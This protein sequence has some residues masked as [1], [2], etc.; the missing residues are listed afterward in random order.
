M[1]H[2]VRYSW[3]GNIRELQNVLERAAILATST[4][5]QIVDP[6]IT[7]DTDSSPETAID[8][9]SSVNTALSLEAIEK[10][11]IERILWARS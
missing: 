11:H 4:Y 7:A 2:L 10:R 5:V 1:Q 3:P 6:T 9:S 8:N